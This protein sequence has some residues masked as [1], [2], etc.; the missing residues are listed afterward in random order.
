MVKTLEFITETLGITVT[1]N[2]WKESNKLPYFLSDEYNFQSVT[3]DSLKCIFITPKEEL[4]IINTLK[5]HLTAIQKF[6]NMHIVVELYSIT[7]QKRKSLIENKIPFVVN[8]KQ[9]YLPFL[10]V[11]LQEKFDNSAPILHQEKLLKLPSL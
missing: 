4:P 6:T 1:R 8:E 5:K 10:G 2:I 3:L 7:R 11:A 9:I